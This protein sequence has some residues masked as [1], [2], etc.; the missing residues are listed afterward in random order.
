MEKD[1]NL[2]ISKFLEEELVSRGAKVVMTRDDDRTLGLRERVDAANEKGAAVLVSIH[3]NALPDNADPN[4]RRGTSVF[5][6]YEQA[7]PLAQSILNAMTSQLGLPDDGVRQASFALVRNT[8]AP[9]VLIE[10][11]YMINPVDNA[12]MVDEAFQQ[13]A[14]KAIADGIGDYLSGNETITE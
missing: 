6:Y 10:V 3:G 14:A 7:K 12:L 8:D 1:I 13:R 9:S 11:G 4:K 2:K 5:Y